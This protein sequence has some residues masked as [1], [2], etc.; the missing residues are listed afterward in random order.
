MEKSKSRSRSSSD[1]KY[2]RGDTNLIPDKSCMKENYISVSENIEDAIT[3]IDDPK[4]QK[5][6]SISNYLIAQV[7][8]L[9][10]AI[11]LLIVEVW[12]N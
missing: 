11:S 6:V 10:A 8:P 9:T 3:F 4:R 1:Q 7:T 12:I 5:E 2:Y